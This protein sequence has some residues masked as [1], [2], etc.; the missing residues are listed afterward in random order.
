MLTRTLLLTSLLTSPIHCEEQQ[1]EDDPT[2]LALFY[3]AKNLRD[4]ISET[5]ANLQDETQ[6]P[7]ESAEA[8]R[9]FSRK[10]FSVV[11]W[12][13]GMMGLARDFV[14]NYLGTNYIFT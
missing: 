8:F 14:F 2:V 9:E 1:E 6:V 4:D 13:T 5:I 7:K 10:W 3:K 11:G 12:S